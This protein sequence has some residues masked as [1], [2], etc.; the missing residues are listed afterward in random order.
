MPDNKKFPKASDL[1]RALRGLAQESEQDVADLS[2]EEVRRE[3][4]ARRIDTLRLSLRVKATIARMRGVSGP[5]GPAIAYW[6]R[7]FMRHDRPRIFAQANFM[8]DHNSAGPDT[9]SE[10]RKQ[11]L[12]AFNRLKE[13]NPGAA[14]PYLARLQSV[15]LQKP[16][17]EELRKLLDDLARQQQPP[18]S[19]APSES[20]SSVKSPHSKASSRKS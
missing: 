11:V 4:A 16:R 20:T 9:V 19:N 3:L 2:A 18:P 12:L 5:V 17:G 7:D 15:M 10:L 13:M 6:A 1:L 14:A 8:R